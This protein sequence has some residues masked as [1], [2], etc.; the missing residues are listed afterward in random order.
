AHTSPD[1]TVTDSSTPPRF[2]HPPLTRTPR[3][4]EVYLRWRSAS[5]STMYPPTTS[6]SSAGDSSSESSAGPS[7]KRCR[8]PAATMT[9]SV[10]A[11]RAL[12][13]S[14]ADLLP[15]HKRFRDSISPE[16][17]VEEDIEADAMAIEV[18]VDR[19]VVTG[20][21]A[22][23]DM[24]VDVDEVEDEVESSDI[25][26]IEVGVD[27][28]AGIDIPDAMLMPDVVE[29]LEQVEEGLQDIYEHVIEIPLQRI[30]DIETG[31]RELESR[32]LIAGGESESHDDGESESQ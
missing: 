16:D 22:G 2:V 23:I 29:R 7:C 30:K 26:T 12:V 25:G 10:H 6:E 31:Q 19:D 17:S 28:A 21:D 5:L 20:V 8:P 11:T 4:S 3:C 15:P 27:V 24:E 9:S 32:S 14:R 1:T 18:A 13:P